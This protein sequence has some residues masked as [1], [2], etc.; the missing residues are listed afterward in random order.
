MDQDEINYK[1]DE[2]PLTLCYGETMDD[3]HWCEM[4]EKKL[5]ATKWFYVCNKCCTTIHL[6]FIF[7]SSVCMKPGSSF[8]EK[9]LFLSV[10]R[11]S[12][13]TRPTCDSFYYRCKDS[14]NY[15]QVSTR[16][17]FRYIGNNWCEVDPYTDSII[18]KQDTFSM[19]SRDNR[20]T[21][22]RTSVICSLDCL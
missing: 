3:T 22:P 8:Y 5:D 10:F 1:Y 6:Q 9:D 4:C 2:H 7:G 19:L 14:I 15:K 13:N 17:V 18:Y 12:S 21:Q 16:T 11:N 20:N